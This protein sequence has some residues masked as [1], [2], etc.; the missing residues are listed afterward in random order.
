MARLIRKA[1]VK[2]V[3]FNIGDKIYFTKF[4][5]DG[6]MGSNYR[7]EGTVVKVNRVTVDMET[8]SGNVYRVEKAE[9]KFC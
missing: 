3:V 5:D 6:R 1:A 7:Y 9:A 8:Q 4:I 2:E